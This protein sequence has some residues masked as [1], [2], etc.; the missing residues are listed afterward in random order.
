MKKIQI[1]VILATVLAMGG[2]NLALPREASAW[3]PTIVSAVYQD[4]DHNG[5]IDRIKLTFDFPVTNCKFETGDWIISGGSVGI[6]GPSGRLNGEGADENCFGTTNYFYLLVSGTAGT[7]GYPGTYVPAEIAYDNQGIL[8]DVKVSG[9][10][11]S[12]QPFTSIGDGASPVVMSSSPAAGA[13]GVSVSIATSS[14]TFSEPM[15]QGTMAITFSGSGWGM[16]GWSTD[17][18]TVTYSRTAD[19]SYGTV[20]NVSVAGEDKN[21]YL[22]SIGNSPAQSTSWSFTT[23]SAPAAV[24]SASQ[25]TLSASP[26]SVAADGSSVSVVTATVKNAA[27]S[28]LA[29]KIVSLSSSRGASD[30]ILSMGSTTGVDGKAYFQVRSTT[31]GSAIFTAIADGVTITQTAAVTFTATAPTL[32]PVSA[33]R[34]SVSASPTSVVANDSD[35]SNVVVTVRDA[36]DNLLS[37]KTVILLSN[38]SSDTVASLPGGSTTNSSGQATFQVRSNTA[39]TSTFT[40]TADGTAVTQ[41]ATVSFTAPTTPPAGL[42]YGD[43]FK[44]SSSSAVYYYGTD[45]KRHVFPTQAIYFSWYSGFFG[46]KTVDHSTVTSVPLGANVV[47]KPGTY[48]VQFVSMDT[49]FGV[50]DPKIYALTQTGQL[51]WITSASVAT[52]LYGSGWERKIVAVP[53]VFRTNYGGGTAISDINSASDYNKTAIESAAS[54]ISSTLP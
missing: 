4:A 24:V 15:A 19:F 50:L 16:A 1:F 46:I 18:K 23:E 7:T 27:G 17:G 43:L 29:G 22:L 5:A 26:T 30:T 47:A 54:T 45:G 31:A 38:R 33:S 37:G 41:T 36:S 35:Y 12:S 32:G 2:L 28:P 48:L 42:V 3:S 53:E 39:G 44:E 40:A 8:D 51:R 20:Y 10:A 21:G 9:V 14:I 49:P 25:S 11:M 34:S 13:T 6:V 52:A